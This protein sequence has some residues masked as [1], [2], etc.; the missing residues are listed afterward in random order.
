MLLIKLDKFY[1]VIAALYCIACGVMNIEVKFT[2]FENFPVQV[3]LLRSTTWPHRDAESNLVAS[4]H[5]IIFQ[6]IN[7]KN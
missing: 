7:A 1:H 6:S 4:L 5:G 2:V 3:T